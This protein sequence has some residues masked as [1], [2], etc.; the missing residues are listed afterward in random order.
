MTDWVPVTVDGLS[1]AGTIGAFAIGFVLLRREHQR[2]E[3]RAEDDRRLQAVKVSAWV[4]VQRTAH[5]GRELLFHVHNA[6]EMPIYEVT[7][8]T[9]YDDDAHEPE[10]IGLVPPGQ[11][12]QR[13]APREWLRTYYSPEPVEIEFL[14]S[15][16]RQWAR[17]EQGYLTSATL[18]EVPVSRRRRLSLRPGRRRSAPSGAEGSGQ[19]G[20]SPG[21]PDRPGRS[22][23]GSP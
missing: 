17:D 15:S 10:F 22:G 7:L 16:G 12:V 21:T 20:R 2:E 5:G 8:P 3:L 13:P 18:S 1:A 19:P 14:D 6:S 11:T 23:S 4:E 9:P